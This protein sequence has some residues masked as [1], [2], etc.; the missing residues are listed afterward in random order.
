MFCSEASL[1]VIRA[2]GEVAGARDSKN[3]QKEGYK[4]HNNLIHI[5]LMHV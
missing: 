3:T 4:H 1:L 5:Q 2:A